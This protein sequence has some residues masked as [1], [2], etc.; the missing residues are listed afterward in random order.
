[1]RHDSIR[2]TEYDINKKTVK[3]NNEQYYQRLLK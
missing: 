1:M 2:D 3:I